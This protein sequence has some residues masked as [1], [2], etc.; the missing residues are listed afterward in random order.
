MPS[1]STESGRFDDDDDEEEE[2]FPF[3][4]DD[5]EEDEEDEDFFPLDDL[6]DLDDDDEEEEDVS[7]SADAFLLLDLSPRRRDPFDPLDGPR[8]VGDDRKNVVVNSSADKSANLVMPWTAVPPT[9]RSFS[10]RSCTCCRTSRN[11]M[12]RFSFVSAS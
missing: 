5:D 2:D 4:D 7:S 1:Q 8:Y 3:F 9:W 12:K 10:L 6:D 11:A